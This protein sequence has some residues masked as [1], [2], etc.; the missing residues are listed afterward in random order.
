[1]PQIWVDEVPDE[2]TPDEYAEY[3]E[4]RREFRAEDDAV[5]EV[6]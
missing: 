2:F 1:M 3:V 6:D 5:E 4:Q